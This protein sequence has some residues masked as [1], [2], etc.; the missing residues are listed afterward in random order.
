M[1]TLGDMTALGVP[2]GGA[3]SAA[4]V[5]MTSATGAGEDV[6]AEPHAR[7]D[8]AAEPRAGGLT[9]R[10]DTWVGAHHLWQRPRPPLERRDLVLALS[11][12]GFGLLSLELIRSLGFLDKTP[13]PVWVQWLAVASGALLLVGRRRFP[14]LIGA[15]A[16]AHMFVLG[17][18]MPTVMG[19][20][21]LQVAYFVAFFSAVAWA[22][23]RRLMRLVVGAIVVFMFGWLA[24]QF[25]LGSGIQDIVD[26]MTGLKRSGLLPPVVAGVALTFLIN[27]IYF[28]AAIVLG[29]LS[30]N[31]ARQRAQLVD[32]SRVL[33]A[34]SAALQRQ[35]VLDERLRIAR[36]LHDV[37]GHH[38]SVIGVQAAAARRV[39]A[40]DPAAATAALSVIESSSR[41]AVSQL[42]GLLGTLRDIE[43]RADP[44]ADSGSG[45][46]TAIRAPEPAV[47]DLPTL[48]AQRRGA[49]L[50]VSYDLVEDEP[51]AAA[52]LP[53]PLGLTLYRVTQEA[54]ANVSRHSTAAT[55]AVVVRVA[56]QGPSPYAE[57]E[58]LDA[59][60]ARVGTSGSGLGLLGIRERAQSLGAT[61][62]I[63][64]RV[65]GGYRVRVR[66]PWRAV[67]DGAVGAESLDQRGMP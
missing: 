60:R 50:E 67:G 51:G 23:D 15:V 17:V 36:E 45:N 30:W 61:V 54:L 62:E 66:I 65:T 20:A 57:V 18:T 22:T 16:A 6:A 26:A 24:W 39:L 10:W 4:S 9:D 41:E 47:A 1:P 43:D 8:V 27:L 42:R 32:Q 46:S 2:R 3:A 37:V 52:R 55:A 63:G 25:A 5:S 64:P 38:V 12:A 49:G 31:G 56:A 19:Q 14:L 53:R 29:Q 34:Q 13:A 48:V 7:E 35:A 21:T 11:V 59:G 40:K 44:R 28:A 33:A 58:V